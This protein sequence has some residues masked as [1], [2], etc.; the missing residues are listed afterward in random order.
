MELW[1]LL[2]K[3]CFL[4]V[5][6]IRSIVKLNEPCIQKKIEEGIFKSNLN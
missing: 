6:E 5:I 4:Q 2:I 1:M 3:E